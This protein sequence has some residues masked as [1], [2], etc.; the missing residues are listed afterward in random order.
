MKSGQLSGK[1]YRTRSLSQNL[2]QIFHPNRQSH[3]RSIN[4][5]S[6]EGGVKVASRSVLNVPQSLPQSPRILVDTSTSPFFQIPHSQSLNFSLQSHATTPVFPMFNFVQPLIVSEPPSKLRGYMRGDHRKN[7][8][9]RSASTEVPQLPKPLIKRSSWEEQPVELNDVVKENVELLRKYSDPKIQYSQRPEGG[10][11]SLSVL[12]TAFKAKLASLFKNKKKYTIA[13][14]P[15]FDKEGQDAYPIHRCD[16]CQSLP[17]MTGNKKTLKP[18]NG[19]R[20]KKTTKRVKKTSLDQFRADGKLKTLSLNPPQM[21]GG[22]F[23]NLLLLNRMNHKRTVMGTYDTYHGRPLLSQ[24]SRLKALYK[25]RKPSESDDTATLSFEYDS[26]EMSDT[27][28]LA[29]SSSDVEEDSSSFSDLTTKSSSRG[30]KLRSFTSVRSMPHVKKL[31]KL[32]KSATT[33]HSLNRSMEAPN[34]PVTFKS[35]DFSHDNSLAQQS[36]IPSHS[37]SIQ[38]HLSHQMSAPT[39][40]NRSDYSMMQPQ[41]SYG[42]VAKPNYYSSL[43]VPPTNVGFNQ[44]P[45]QMIK[46]YFTSGPASSN[47]FPLVSV[48]IH[49][50][51]IEKIGYLNDPPTQSHSSMDTND[52]SYWEVLNV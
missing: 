27:S 47:D 39:L 31:R 38:Y 6:N 11:S 21:I 46:A 44:N 24:A 14:P 10:A 1:Y 50:I 20:E 26:G 42:Q 34:F 52:F 51:K 28:S 12:Q 8:Y 36:N 22:S 15:T 33:A 25:Y 30:Y 29:R 43:S 16:S 23:D 35:N 13:E 3:S 5:L 40:N 45:N 48:T 9:T 41:P 17:T 32:R 2:Q 37:K 18:R 7:Q 19:K 49:S 4:N